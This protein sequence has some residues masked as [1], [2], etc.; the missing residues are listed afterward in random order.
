MISQYP[1]QF[2]P[3]YAVPPGETLKETL[4]ARGMSQADLADR[5][6]R[7]RKTINEIIAGK[8]AITSE[9][10]LQLERVLGVPASFWNALERRY[11]ETLARLAERDSLQEQV[12]WLRNFPVKRMMELGW[13]PQSNDKVVQLQALLGFFGVASISVWQSRSAQQQTRFRKSQSAES[14]RFAVAAWLRRGE[15][16][17]AEIGCQ[18]Y[19]AQRFRQTLGG[20]RRLTVS[21]PEVFEPHLVRACAEAGVAVVFVPELPRTRTHGAAYWLAP[22]KAVIQ[23][24]LRYKTDDHFWFSFFHEAVHVLRHH[25]TLIFL[26]GDNSSEETE[27]NEMAAEFLIPA[28][29][30]TN[31]AKR[32]MFRS[33]QA[34]RAFAQALAISPGIVVGRMQHD[35]LLPYTHLNRLKRQFAWKQ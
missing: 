13:L 2:T 18:A 16:L 26:D 11:R 12:E 35:G 3:N 5:T 4:V 21:P 7:P 28:N 27:A 32:P 20:A 24:S 1:N 34:I 23:L 8:T 15:L 22:D 14:D 30:L 17:A 29:K 31:F 33:E 19:D 10:A 9:T 6:G 25:P